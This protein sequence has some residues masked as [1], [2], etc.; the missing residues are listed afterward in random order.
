MH[1]HWTPALLAFGVAVAGTAGCERA[2]LHDLPI[3]LEPGECGDQTLAGDERCDE[4]TANSD[5]P[6]ATC[7]SDCTLRRCGDGVTDDSSEFGEACDAGNAN[8][9]TSDA[10]CRRNCTLPFCG[11]GITD[12][13]RDEVCDAGGDN[14]DTPDATCR[15]DCQSQRCG[16]G[17]IDT[18]EQC[19]DGD[20]SAGDGCG[21]TCQVEIGFGCDG[22][23]SECRAVFYVDVDAT[24]GGD[25][26]SWADAFTD[27]TDALT[28]A[29]ASEMI[30]IAAGTYRP[31]LDAGGGIPANPRHATFAPSPGVA[32]YG[33][34]AGNETLLSQRDPG[35]HTATLSGDIGTL[36]DPVDNCRH[37][38]W[39]AASTQTL[40]ING[41]TITGGHADPSEPTGVGG[42]GIVCFAGCRVR[43]V[44]GILVDNAAVIGGALVIDSGGDVV[45]RDSVFADNQTIEMAGYSDEGGAAIYAAG[46]TL[47]I[48]GCLFQDNIADSSP[49]HR[50]GAVYLISQPS[51]GF[52]SVTT[53]TNSVFQDNVADEG[54]GIYADEGALTIVGSSFERG[55]SWRGGG[56]STHVV[57]PL[58][59][60]A[61]LFYGNRANIPWI[62]PA[63]GGA[64]AMAGLSGGNP[65]DHPATI[66]NSIFVGNVADRG[67]GI[68]SQFLNPT[69]I[70]CTFVDNEA[71][72]SASSGGALWNFWG[73][74][75]LQ[76]SILVR[77]AGGD[78]GNDTVDPAYQTVVR[79]SCI[80][81]GYDGIG[82]IDV[83][84][85]LFARDPDDGGDGWGDAND[86]HGDLHLQ[87]GSPCLGIGDNNAL[88]EELTTDL[89]GN[90]RIAG[91]DGDVDA[92][93]YERP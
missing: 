9:D 30:W 56:I 76:N 44:N 8:A 91:D 45:V 19:D 73:I 78:I 18:G 12:P 86:D 32:I 35:L 37:V 53:V 93:A 74:P 70:N 69:I 13:G 31:R 89:D 68:W 57:A 10:P 92:G 85:P 3:L 36:G 59:V 58:T 26:S 77:N 28:S 62:F 40:L 4:G 83:A 52:H 60:D 55:T 23:P 41:I 81:G 88:P 67:G 49:D 75:S 21:T 1:R 64:V 20:A 47:T 65:D 16:D 72:L 43:I 90:P 15:L 33:G 38:V 46:S 25:G 48:A 42:G 6:N 79:H 17:I 11:D 39:V 82:N 2:F 87:D 7:R 5:E 27:L 80:Q 24:G 71:V 22:I 14:A 61:S 63:D 50:G 54:A 84:D 29:N 51:A 34:F 66:S